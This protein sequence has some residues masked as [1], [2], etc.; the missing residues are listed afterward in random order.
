MS[1][2]FVEY[3]RRVRMAQQAKDKQRLRLRDLY[4][5]GTLYMEG[6]PDRSFAV[7][8]Q[9]RDEARNL[10]DKWWELFFEHQRLNSVTYW[11]HDYSRALPL[12][13]DLLVRFNQPEGQSHSDR[14][15]VLLGVLGVYE[16]VDPFGYRQEIEAGI[17]HLDSQVSPGP[18]SLRFVLDHLKMSVLTDADRWAEAKDQALRTLN[19]IDQWPVSE[20][21][22][23][24]HTCWTHYGLCRICHAMGQIGELT[25][26]AER[27][28]ELSPKRGNLRRTEADGLIWLAFS[29]R[30]RGDEPAGS[31]HFHRAVGILPELETRDTVVADSMAAYLESC[32]DFRTAVGVRERELAVAERKH[33]FHRACETHLHRCRLLGK[34]GELTPADIDAARAATR[35]LRD[36]GW[37]GAKID[38]LDPPG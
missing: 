32:G 35:K 27:M 16:S 11:A 5:E 34:L 14:F 33:M 37:F 24:W 22:R 29:A 20:H 8:T 1:D 7:F 9:G 31:R 17:Q 38:Q 12:A 25:A 23:Y 10:R 19:L 3:R 36:P 6:D 13:M 2:A 30:A 18:G 15:W 4:Q 21:Y 28:L 26:H